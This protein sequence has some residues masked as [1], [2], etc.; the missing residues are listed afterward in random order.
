MIQLNKLSVNFT[1]DFL[2]HDVSF[3]AGD[4][5]RIGLVGHNGAGKST[6]LKIIH[7]VQEPTSG[8]MVITTGFRTGYLPQE[9]AE[10]SYKTVWEETMSAFVEVKS[11]EER[12]RRLTAQLGERTDYESEEYATLAQQLSDANDRYVHLGGST[13]EGEAEKVLT[14]MGFRRTDFP[15]PMAEFSNGW[16]M[17]VCLAKILLQKPEIVLLD[18][19][20]NHLDIESIQW[21]EDYLANYDGCV[22][23]V[24]HDRAFLDRVTNRTVEITLGTIQDYKCS[25]SQYVEQRLERIE[26]QQAAYENQQQQIAQIE[27]FIERFRYKATKARQVQSRLK[28]LE[29]MDR[30]QV[31]DYDTSSISFRFPPAPHSGRMV[32]DAK[33]LSLGYDA[34]NVLH[35]VDF[36]LERGERVAFVGRNGEGKS[37]MVKAIVGQ[38]APQGGTLDLGYQVVIGYYAQNQA[39]LLDPE[40]TVF[41]TIDDV[42]VG[43]IRPKIR[44]ILG[45]FLFD[46]EA[47]EKKVK[48]LS[49]GEKARLA[50]A[51]LLLSPFNL[52]ILDEPTNH[53]DMPS[54]DVLKNALLQ[55][56]GSLILVSHD[57]DFLQGLS[58]KTYEFKDKQIRGYVGDVYDFLEARKIETLNELQKRQQVVSGEAKAVSSNKESYEQRKAQE[59]ADRKKK[60]RLR[61]IEDEIESLQL[62]VAEIEDKL[63]Q[64]DRYAAEIASGELYQAYE[65]AKQAL[66]EK[67]ME[68]LELESE[69]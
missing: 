41:E 35:K 47:T 61:K 52:L 42:A 37:T 19:P 31:E 45:S 21:L 28:M 48:V 8:T 4:K 44:T 26:S 58:T 60:N 9:L 67:E 54:K 32:V 27:R 55:Y 3:V 30:V 53:L 23:L 34:L 11:I 6:L 10:T 17:R 20:T 68:W 38:L 40:K 1:G 51:K 39:K 18:E 13:I 62:Q 5:D 63:A 59:A 12:M 14:G 25:Y 2:F 50:L 66:E 29:K 24:S 49:G 43:D 36:H 56:E 46:T 57:R 22:I 7:R 65:A 64:P 69:Q 15:R 16:Q 33:Q